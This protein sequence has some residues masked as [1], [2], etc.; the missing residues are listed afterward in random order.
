M[1]IQST[2]ELYKNNSKRVFIVFSLSVLATFSIMSVYKPNIASAASCVDYTFR[3]GSTGTCVRYIQTL[4]N[5]KLPYIYNYST[6]LVDGQYGPVTKGGI[7]RIQ[8]QWGLY[9]DGVV[10]PQTWRALCSTGTISAY[11]GGS[12]NSAELSAYWNAGCSKLMRIQ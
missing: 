5:H 2:L 11:A 1:S 6:L 12:F 8:K 10:G 3:R 4:A 9:Y 7:Y